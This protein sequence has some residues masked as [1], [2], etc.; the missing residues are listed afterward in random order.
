M[1]RDRSQKLRPDRP[2]KYDRRSRQDSAKSA[3][4]QAARYLMDEYDKSGRVRCRSS[5]LGGKEHSKEFHYEISLRG[6]S[7]QLVPQRWNNW[8]RVCHANGW[9][10]FPGKLM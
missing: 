8:P 2:R 6:W 5:W 1:S 3:A 7:G 10:R 9:D 4:G